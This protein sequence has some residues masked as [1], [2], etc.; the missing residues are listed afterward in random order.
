[1]DNTIPK[2]HLAPDDYEYVYIPLKLLS[3]HT[4]EQFE[5]MVKALRGMVYVEMRWC[6]NGLPQEGTLTN[7][8]L[9]ERLAPAK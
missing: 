4:I 9:K 2:Q 8:I 7:K 5:L 6:I 3:E 1:M